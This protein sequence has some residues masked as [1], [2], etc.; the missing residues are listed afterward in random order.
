[1]KHLAKNAVKKTAKK[2][3][4]FAGR[5]LLLILAPFIPLILI[6]LAALFF[7]ALLV[8][9][10]YGSMA[11]QHAMTGVEQLPEKDKEI[12][13]HYKDLCGFY[14]VK[15]TWL[16]NEEAATP[17]RGGA[18]EST[19]DAPFYPGTG[20][21]KI[22]ELVDR[23]RNDYKLRLEWPVVHSVGLFWAFSQGESEI[24]ESMRE[25][26]AE[27]THPYYY[28]KKSQVI[29]T[30]TG[31]GGESTTSIRE[32]YLLVEAYTIYGHY[33]YHYEWHTTYGENSSTTAERLKDI[34][35]ILPNRWQRFDDY[36][37]EAYELKADDDIELNRTF[38]LEA[39]EGYDKQKEWMDWLIDKV[40]FQYFV[41]SAMIPPD[42]IMYFK[43]AEEEYGIPWWFLAAVSFQES[44]FNPQ[45]ENSKSKCYGLMQLTPSNWEHYSALL[46]FDPVHDRDSPRAQIMCGAYMLAKLG[47]ENVDWKRDDW[48]EQTLP[49]LTFYGGFVKVPANKPYDSP[50]EWCRAEYAS[51]I[52]DVAEGFTKHG[53]A[54]WPVPGYTHISS[55]YGWRD[56]P[57]GKTENREYHGGI[58][59][60]ADTGTPI[61]SVS[62]GTVIVAASDQWNGNH[63]KI[64]DAMHQYTYCHM[65]SIDVKVGDIVQPGQVIGKVGST[66]RSTG[67]HLH[68][69]VVDLTN[70]CRIDPLT[71]LQR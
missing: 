24:S 33:Q 37:I 53:S 58:D 25:K 42:L 34:Q 30:T 64:R 62:A 54:I 8:A 28:Y 55:Y 19:P 11:P 39:A 56:D 43:E 61:V 35:Q 9:S 65:D 71:L 22:G 23:F 49:I 51:K 3:V 60:P 47:L 1:M 17:E 69:E 70:A 63:V 18:Y 57:T 32:V 48:Q 40:G 41:S 29:T 50:E 21:Q 46:G 4:K 2:A 31:E 59:I 45:A 38:V 5:K 12:I 27:D 36:I 13:R 6:F 14:N 20:T 15:D 7:I 16:I 44:S 10:I 67:P 68:F 52:W 66:G 26:F